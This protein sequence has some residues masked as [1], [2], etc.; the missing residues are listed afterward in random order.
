VG[1]H[2]CIRGDCRPTWSEPRRHCF[3]MRLETHWMAACPDGYHVD[4]MALTNA[5]A[6]CWEA[7]CQGGQSS[8]VTAGGF[9]CCND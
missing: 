3:W 1:D 6:G 7:G 9:L 5:S 2:L 8:W 4:G